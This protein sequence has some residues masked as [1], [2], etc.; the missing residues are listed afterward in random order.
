MAKTKEKPGSHS[1]YFEKVYTDNPDLLDL[2]S[3]DEVIKRWQQDNGGQEMPKNVRSVMANKKS[4]MRKKLGK[5]KRRRRRGLGAWR[6][7]RG[8]W[9]RPA[10]RRSTRPHSRRAASAGTR[11]SADP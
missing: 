10:G 5:V 4:Q 2:S 7:G 8:L 6:G 1:A 11:V 9:S 3:N